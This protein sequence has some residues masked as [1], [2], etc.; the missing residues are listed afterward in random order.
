ME[1]ISW[2]GS[3]SSLLVGREVGGVCY[4]GGKW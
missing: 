4:L 3:E 1:S 2:E